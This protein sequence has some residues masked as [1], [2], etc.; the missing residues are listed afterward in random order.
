MMNEA[1]PFKNPSGTIS[2]FS[3]LEDISC[4]KKGPMVGYGISFV[5]NVGWIIIGELGQIY[6]G[7]DGPLSK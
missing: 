3:F 4:Q 6:H 1:R 7:E 2:S 5:T